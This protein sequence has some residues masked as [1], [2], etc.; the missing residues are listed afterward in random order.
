MNSRRKRPMPNVITPTTIDAMY[1]TNMTIAPVTDEYSSPSGP[2]NRASRIAR[3]VLFALTTITLRRE[4][5]SSNKVK[6]PSIIFSWTPQNTPARSELNSFAL[7]QPKK[8]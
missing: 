8:A 1:R 5:C 3:A 6:L 4:C 7:C 2:K